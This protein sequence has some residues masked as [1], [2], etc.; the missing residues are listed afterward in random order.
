MFPIPY[1]L[2][3][4]KY[5]LNVLLFYF[6]EIFSVDLTVTSLGFS[7]GSMISL[8]LIYI[9]KQLFFKEFTYKMFTYFLE[10]SL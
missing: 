6:N 7:V 1:Q 8:I 4:D 2:L 10:H 5:N 9:K 3:R